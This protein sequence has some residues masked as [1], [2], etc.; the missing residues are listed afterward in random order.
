MGAAHTT[1]SV[2]PPLERIR[3]RRRARS[4]SSKSSVSEQ[5]EIGPSYAR[6][7]ST[8]NGSGWVVRF[9]N[10]ISSNVG[11]ADWV[12][13]DYAYTKRLS[14][15]GDYL[16]HAH[17]TLIEGDS[18]EGEQVFS[19]FTDSCATKTKVNGQAKTCRS[20]KYDTEPGEEWLVVSDHTYDDGNDGDN[21]ASIAGEL[22]WVWTAS[23]S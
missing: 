19:A 22:D 13:Y 5:S 14:G 23:S 11:A 8:E 6:Q 2:L 16:A 7:A 17:A 1:M 10:S 3:A 21:D 15:A 9:E 18:Y 4:R 20:S 12:K